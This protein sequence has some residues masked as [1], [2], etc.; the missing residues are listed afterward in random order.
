MFTNSSI[1]QSTDKFIRII[2]NAKE[3]VKADKAK[4]EFSINELKANSYNQTED[5]D[6]KTV[7]KEVIGK[8]ESNGFEESEI[9]Q[10]IS[11]ISR[12]YN[13]NSKQFVLETDF[14]NLEK[15]SSIDHPGF[16]V[17]NIS[18][19]Y[20]DFDENL[21]SELSLKA[22][23]D[24]KRKASFLCEKIDK[25]LGEILNIE[26]KEGDFGSN[27]RENKEEQKLITYR[28]TITFQLDN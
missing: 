16:R 19:I 17:T 21:E 26:V 10:S 5:K 14:Q 13:A 8:F 7:Y 28:V 11:N 24:A 9:Q 3:E 12:G 22:I 1:A 25:K 6:Y 20:S 23:E 18:Y 15:I 4:I 2:G 27:I